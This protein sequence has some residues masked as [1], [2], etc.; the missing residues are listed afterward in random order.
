MC[1]CVYVR[2]CVCVSSADIFTRTQNMLGTGVCGWMCDFGESVPLNASLSS[3]QNP[4]QFHSQYPGLW[5]Q[6]NAD[7]ISTASAQGLLRN[8][9]SEED[10]VFFMRAGNAL[11]PGKSRFFWLGDQTVTWDEHDGLATA[12]T[13]MISGGISGYS[14]THSDIGGYTAVHKYFIK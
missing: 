13:G 8:N 7:A 12:I 11:S 14:L 9:C 10:V 1:V 3:G 6:L 4:R 2:V 5:A